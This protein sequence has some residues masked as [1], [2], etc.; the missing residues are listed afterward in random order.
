MPDYLT[1]PEILAAVQ[2]AIGPITLDPCAYEG[3]AYHVPAL[4]RFT[5]K[6]DGLN[7]PWQGTVFMNPPYGS[8]NVMKWVQKLNMEF[9]EGRVDKAIALLPSSTDAEW[10]QIAAEWVAVCFVKGRLHFMDVANRKLGRA[11]FPIA[12]FLVNG[13]LKSFVK[14]FRPF[15][16]IWVPG[17]HAIDYSILDREIQRGEIA[18]SDDSEPW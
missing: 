5:K 7:L 13:H 1:P 3:A 15:G 18:G 17:W 6:D 8:N 16:N 12:I 10:W 11:P 14:E 4:H 2:R 9:L